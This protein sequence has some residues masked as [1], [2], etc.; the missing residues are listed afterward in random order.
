MVEVAVVEASVVGMIEGRGCGS[1][2]TVLVLV[3]VWPAPVEQSP[4]AGTYSVKE[5]IMAPEPK[6][7][8]PDIPAQKPDIQ[9]EPRPVEIPQDKDLPEKES[10]PM[11]V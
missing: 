10:P 8:E 6:R 5:S 3:A 2:L 4:V 1:M 7:Q 9:P 11:Q